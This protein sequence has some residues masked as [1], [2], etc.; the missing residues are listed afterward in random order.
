MKTDIQDTSLE[1]YKDIKGHLGHREDQVY[2]AIEELKFATI[3]MI[4]E[5]TGLLPNQITGRLKDLREKHKLVGYAYTGK[6]PIA[7]KNCLFW[8]IVR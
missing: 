6:C 5:R 8:K 2:Q 1:A 4:S 7:K 3:K